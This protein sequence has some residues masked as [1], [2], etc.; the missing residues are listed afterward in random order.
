MMR[1]ET[2]GRGYNQKFYVEQTNGQRRE[3]GRDG[4]RPACS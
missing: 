2:I 1:D 4:G 3:G